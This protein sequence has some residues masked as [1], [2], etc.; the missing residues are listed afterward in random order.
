MTQLSLF[1]GQNHLAPQKILP[2]KIIPKLW[3]NWRPHKAYETMQNKQ[4][5]YFVGQ[6][7]YFSG[8]P[9]SQACLG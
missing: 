8:N 9:Q 3:R 2:P 5:C 1:G 7:Y 6:N 4:A